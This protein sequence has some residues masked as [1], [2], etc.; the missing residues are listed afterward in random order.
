MLP[1]ESADGINDTVHIRNRY[2]LHVAVEF[3]EASFDLFSV[4]LI[5]LAI[6]IP[7]HF[8]NGLNIAVAVVWWIGFYV[9]FQNVKI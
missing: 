3:S 4:H 5:V 2:I 6:G 7:E 1:T 9:G 8:Q